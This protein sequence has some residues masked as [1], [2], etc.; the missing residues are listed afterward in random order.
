MPFLLTTKMG[1]ALAA[2]WGLK[3][4][5]ER[6]GKKKKK[7]IAL[8]GFLTRIETKKKKKN[9]ATG[10]V[11]IRGKKKQTE[12]GDAALS[13]LDMSKPKKKRQGGQ[14]TR[15]TMLGVGE[16][17]KEKKSILAV[18]NVRNEW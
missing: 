13:R 14:G 9:R 16:K 1:T 8:W 6:P 3:P 10:H 2:L 5:T 4:A 17:S 18:W 15:W 12:K 11:S 7:D